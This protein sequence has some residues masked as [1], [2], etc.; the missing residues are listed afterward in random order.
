MPSRSIGRYLESILSVASD[1]WV[2][3]I[4][5]AT[6]LNIAAVT[7][8]ISVTNVENDPSEVKSADRNNNEKNKREEIPRW[9]TIWSNI[10]RIS[11]LSIAFFNAL[12]VYVTYRLVTST[13]NLW[14]AGREQ[15]SHLQG[16]S[17]RQLRAYVYAGE[18]S[19]AVTISPSEFI[20]SIRVQIKNWGTTPA[21]KV[22]IANYV[23]RFPYP[24]PNDY[25]VK[26]PEWD[27]LH[28]IGLAPGQFIH[29]GTT[30]RGY[31]NLAAGERYYMIGVVEYCDVFGGPTRTTKYCLSTDVADFIAKHPDGAEGSPM[32]EIA[33]QHN[34]AN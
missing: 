4:V 1:G 23:D 11:T 17:E 3:I 6:L 12:L 34:E 5:L 9:I 24:L 7:V 21:Y 18:P 33:P 19:L 27:E 16:S 10:D 15:L 22:R 28:Y 30:E 29:H 14:V 32:F 20:F 25:V 31:S 13:D 8:D 26:S 2:R